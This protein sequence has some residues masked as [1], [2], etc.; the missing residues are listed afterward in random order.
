MRLKL[1]GTRQRNQGMTSVLAMMFLVLFA[2][3]A[4]GFYAA[5]NVST[6][7]SS[8][9]E[10]VTRA[11]FA[12]ESGLDFMRYQLAQIHL[13]ST[14][15]ATLATV[16]NLL[17]SQLNG[18]SNLRSG[19]ITLSGNTI[20]IPG[21]SSALVNLDAKGDSAF[22]LTVNEDNGRLVVKSVGYYGGT[23]GA[24][25]AISMDFSQKSRKVGAFDYAVASK[26]QIISQK[27]AVTSIAGVDPAI[28]QMMSADAVSNSIV[29]SGG[30]IGGDLNVVDGGAAA[31]TGGTVGGSSIPSIILS[32]HVHDVDAPE[33]PNIDPTAYKKYATGGN[34]TGAKTQQNIIVPAGTNPKFN[35]N[36]TINGIMYVQAPNTVTFNGNLALNGFIVMESSAAGTLAFSGN[37]TMG[38]VPNGAAFN[39]ARTVSGIAILA[40]NATMQMTGSSGGNLRGNVIVGKFS[41]A[42]ASNLII[43]Q[44]TIMTLTTGSSSAVF[45]S[46]KSIQFSSTGSNNQPNTGMTYSTYYEPLPA[47]YQEVVQ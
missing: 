32:Q 41:Y 39:D 38:P 8:N 20:L 27:G 6:Q 31:V 14:Q 12:A 21:S 22:Q 40:P 28:A 23:S 47:T 37:V 26:G 2:T 43:D 7:V 29:V 44:G 15:P 19:N 36:T 24:V 18:T 16:Y 3:L 17:Q 35:G 4:L 25:R 5:T 11:S 33:F 13:P 42:G 45:N 10:H 1:F 9:D 34:N 46:A 30:T